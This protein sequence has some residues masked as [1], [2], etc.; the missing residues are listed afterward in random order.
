MQFAER[1]DLARAKGARAETVLEY[2]RLALHEE[3]IAVEALTSVPL[4]VAAIEP[5]RSVLCRSAAS[6]AHE[7]GALQLASHLVQIGLAGR[8]PDDIGE[9]LRELG[10]TVEAEQTDARR[11]LMGSPDAVT[12]ISESYARGDRRLA[13][14]LLAEAMA[15]FEPMR[16]AALERQV[17]GRVAAYAEAGAA[18]VLPT[19]LIGDRLPTTDVEWDKRLE[20]LEQV[21]T[22]EIS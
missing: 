4:V 6:L 14:I 12:L 21:E 19:G 20:E 18:A 7:V 11:R 3:L 17:S 8:A 13:N 22:I 2:L 16:A 15:T 1:A 5:S 9:E 10:A